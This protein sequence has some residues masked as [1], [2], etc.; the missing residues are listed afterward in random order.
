MHR[1]VIDATRGGFMRRHLTIVGIAL[2]LGAGACGSPAE[3]PGVATA[4][5][6]TPAPSPTANVLAQYVDAQRAWVKCMREH[7]YNLPDPDAKG[8]VDLGAF[9]AETKLP[10]TDAGFI[11]A[12]QACRS[13]QQPVPAELGP[14]I[15]PLTAEQIA[16]RRKYAKCMR[17]N[18][19]PSWPDPGPDGEWPATGALGETLSPAEAAANERALQICD[20]VLDGKPQGSFD[21]NKVGQG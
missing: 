15:P 11:A 18:G 3:T 13:F 12:Q 6:G 2:A 17:A 20:P 1:Q 7:N 5:S 8:F 9:L 4:A 14:S 21:P 10:K 19:M 16:N